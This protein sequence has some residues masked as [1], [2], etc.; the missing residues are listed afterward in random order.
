MKC[1]AA[2]VSFRHVMT[3]ARMTFFKL[4]K[5]TSF[6]CPIVSFN[7][8]RKRTFGFKGEIKMQLLAYYDFA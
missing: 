7:L 2:D 5:V 4:W 3:G 1:A 8:F 6:L